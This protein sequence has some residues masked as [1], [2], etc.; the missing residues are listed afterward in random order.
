MGKQIITFGDI[1]VEKYKFD[2]Y[3]SPIFKKM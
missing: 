3:K 1:E 2:R